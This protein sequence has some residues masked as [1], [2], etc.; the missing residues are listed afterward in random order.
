MFGLDT[1]QII[2][3]IIGVTLGCIIGISA[4]NIFGKTKKK[5]ASERRKS[6]IYIVICL[7]LGV[8]LEVLFASL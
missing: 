1:L 4:R 5:S 6:V 8:I 7:I 2:Q 3:I